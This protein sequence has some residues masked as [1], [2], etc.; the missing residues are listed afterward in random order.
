MAVA[1]V[2]GVEERD[3]T[4]AFSPLGLEAEGAP[5]FRPTGDTP[6]AAAAA[7]LAVMAETGLG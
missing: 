6:A 2:E 1:G 4:E 7:L 3:V 5:S